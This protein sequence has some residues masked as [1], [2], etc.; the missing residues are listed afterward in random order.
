[1]VDEELVQMSDPK[2]PVDPDSSGRHGDEVVVDP[3]SSGRQADEV[4]VD[5][6]S[7]GRHGDE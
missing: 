7:S 2:E 6:D 1:M 5:P 4:V 3:D